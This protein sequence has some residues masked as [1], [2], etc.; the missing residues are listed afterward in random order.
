MASSKSS[1]QRALS[2]F[3][4][5]IIVLIILHF[6][7]QDYTNRHVNI[8]KMES[9]QYIYF[10]QN[11]GKLTNKAI[12]G[13]LINENMVPSIILTRHYWYIRSTWEEEELKKLNE[14]KT[15]FSITMKET[16]NPKRLYSGNP[17]CR[18]HLFREFNYVNQ[19]T[20]RSII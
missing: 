15:C 20:S 13:C 6:V 16:H 10:H 12:F 8:S 7:M 1:R 5:K 2:E 18:T 11:S 9:S 19:T 17:S 14:W 3:F 4:A